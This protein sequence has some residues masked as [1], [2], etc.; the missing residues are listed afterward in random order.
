MASVVT[1]PHIEKPDDKPARLARMPR[2][3]VYQ[4]VMDYLY[5]HWT[6]EEMVV[7]Y[8]HLELAEVYA[9][10]TYYFD[11]Q[12]EIASE[13]KAT[14]ELVERLRAEAE[15]NPPPVLERLRAI[16]RQRNDDQVS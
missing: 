5:H 4:I 12:E 16:K 9:A 3:K 6:P 11:H 1:Y 13:I 10:M 15:K 14:S 8:P 7:H 2:I